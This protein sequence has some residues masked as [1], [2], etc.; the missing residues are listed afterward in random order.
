MSRIRTCITSNMPIDT[1]ATIRFLSSL[2][3]KHLQTFLN[4]FSSSDAFLYQIGI[5]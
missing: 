4:T 1:C 3:V 2:E 5:S